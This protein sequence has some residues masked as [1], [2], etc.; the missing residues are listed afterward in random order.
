MVFMVKEA[1]D[2]KISTFP[3]QTIMYF[4]Y[5]IVYLQKKNTFRY[6]KNMTLK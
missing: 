3:N 5:Y 4:F 2:I 1:V 6:V